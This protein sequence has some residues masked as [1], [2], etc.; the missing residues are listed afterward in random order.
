MPAACSFSCR[1]S[2]RKASIR[3]SCVADAVA[4]SSAEQRPA[5][6]TSADRTA[7]RTGS[8]RHQHQLRQHQP[9]APAAEP[10]RQHRHI[11]RIDD[12]RPQEFD[13][14]G[15]ADQREQADG[16]EVDADFR[17]IQS[18]QR[19]AG[20][21]QRQPR[22]EAEEQDDEHAR[23]Q[24]D[25]GASA[26]D[27]AGAYVAVGGCRHQL[28]RLASFRGACVACEPGIH[29]P[30]ATAYGFGFAAVAAP[31]NDR[32]S[33]RRAQR[34]ADGRGQGVR[35]IALELNVPRSSRRVSKSCPPK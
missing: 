11:E 7:P 31:R 29:T 3:M 25:R 24:I 23:L 19:R 2:M 13:G 26:K 27:G 16:L 6:A 20:Q 32:K 21:R 9:A 12:R 14:V 4:T 15:R 28:N 34:R 35:R 30:L 10:A 5:T 33:L 22:R 1:L 17:R 8:P 18:Q